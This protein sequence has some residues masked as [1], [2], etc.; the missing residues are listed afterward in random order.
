M[1]LQF[2]GLKSPSVYSPK[3]NYISISVLILDPQTKP[4]IQL[5]IDRS[6]QCVNSWK[7]EFKKETNAMFYIMVGKMGNSN[8]N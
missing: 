6:V 7:V 1:Y 4:Y 8:R 5:D 3:K 2:Y